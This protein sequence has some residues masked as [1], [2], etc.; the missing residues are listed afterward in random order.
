MHALQQHI[1]KFTTRYLLTKAATIAQ[2]AAHAAAACGATA[3]VPWRVLPLMVT[4]TVEPTAFLADPR[5]PCTTADHLA[6]VL[7]HPADPEPGWIPAPAA[8]P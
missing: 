4:R 6:T 3:E 7:T 5:I 1:K 8:T 2:Y